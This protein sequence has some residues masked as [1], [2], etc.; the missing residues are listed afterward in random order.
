MANKRGI[1]LLKPL[2]V[3]K[4]KLDKTKSSIELRDGGGLFLL[5]K[6]PDRK[7]WIYR[8]TFPP[9][10]PENR[11]GLGAYP[12]VSLEEARK[13]RD[14]CNELKAIGTHPNEWNTELKDKMSEYDDT[15][16]FVNVYK[17]FIEHKSKTLAKPSIVRYEG[18]WNNYLE[19]SLKNKN[20]LKLTGV[21][22]V[23][24]MR[25][26]ENNPVPLRS[27][28]TD[29]KKYPRKVTIKYAKTLINQVYQHAHEEMG[30]EGAN[31]IDSIKTFKVFKQN[32][33]VKHKA[34]NE[35]D[36]GKYWHLVKN[37]EILQ[38]KIYMQVDIITA[39]RVGSLAQ[40][41]WSMFNPSKKL[42]SL[43]KELL[44]T[45]IEFATPLPDLLVD[46]LREL[47]KMTNGKPHDYIFINRKGEHYNKGRPRLLVKGM[48]FESATAHGNRTI[49]KLNA[50][51]FSNIS[52]FAIEYQL[53]HEVATK[54]RNEG[55]YMSDYDWLKERR[56]LVDWFI[57]YL[58]SLEKVYVD[59]Q[60][61]INKV[62]TG[63]GIVRTAKK[64]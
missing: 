55:S 22:I 50:S 5:V 13:R 4:Y 59:T 44:K 53:S 23:A 29:I 6:R 1:N 41:K 48:G 11:L 2:E 47:K 9:K 61:T 31:P 52:S 18:I 57:N 33:A 3:K 43:P 45:R 63:N 56:Q 14:R 38:D 62:R 10:T 26:I 51:R 8:Y 25:N 24:L 42:L 39:L 32:K 28:K 34:V 17:A 20:L 12:E 60:E 15:F 49:L 30:F 7:S 16:L 19:S 64:S 27:G 40:A 54:D 58:D 46:E 21:E 35:E 37:L 36:L